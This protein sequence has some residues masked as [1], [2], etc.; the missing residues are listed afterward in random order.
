VAHHIIVELSHAIPTSTTQPWSLDEAFKTVLLLSEVMY[1][2]HIFAGPAI[3]QNPSL[4]ALAILQVMYS[5]CIIADLQVC[6]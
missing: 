4:Q 2:H 1:P 5:H 6:K 3:L